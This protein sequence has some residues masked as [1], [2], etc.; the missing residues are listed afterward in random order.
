[1]AQIEALTKAFSGHGIEENALIAILGNS[2]PEQRKSFRKD[3]PY[4]INDDE[5]NLEKWN[6]NIIHLLEHEFLRFKKAVVLW[7]M[8][9]W[10]RDARLIKEALVEA[11]QGPHHYG[12]IVEVA[13]T[14][15]SEQLYGARRAYHSLFDHSIEEDVATHING[16]ERKLLVALVS[17][18]RYEGSKINE[19][20]A[21]SE[22]KTLA[23]AIQSSDTKNPIEDDDVVRILS[24][25]SKPHLLEVYK[26]YQQISG[27]TIDEDVGV[28]SL[29]GETVQ[30]LSAPYT[31]FSKVLDRSLKIDANSD[32]KNALARVITT[33]ADSD[34]SVIDA[35]Y[36]NLYGG[37]SLSTKIEEV[38]NGSYK[39]FLLTLMA[40]SD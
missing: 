10:E 31:Y 29:L 17:A 6:D 11:H 34:I 14:R 25:R 28:D 33:R 4:F 37:V 16:S 24:T 8:H 19:G 9:P 21:K 36:Q 1:M 2:N 27:N 26:H 20:A 3:S 40:R 12:V 5:R 7:A 15:S 18:Y 39:A 13:C 22:A 23:S 32:N 30:C 38:A 35:E